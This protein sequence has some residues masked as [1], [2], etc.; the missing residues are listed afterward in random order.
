MKILVI[1]N[2]YL[3]KGGEDRV[4]DSE[5][6]M[7]KDAGNQV[8]YYKCSNNDIKSFGFFKKIKFLF[9]DINWNRKSYEEIKRIARE[10]K[11]DLAHIHNIFIYLSSSAYFA[12]KEVGI[13]VVQTLH[14][15]RLICLKGTFYAN[16]RICEDCLSGNYLKA[17]FK[18]CWRDSFILSAFLAKMLYKNT[19]SKI[20]QENV[21]AFI[22]LSEFSRNKFKQAGFPEDKLFIK[23]N[24]VDFKLSAEGKKRYGLFLGRL[25]DYKGVDTLLKA[26]AKLDKHYLKI[27]G[28]GPMLNEVKNR[29]K[30]SKNIQLL[31]ALP[32]E[33][34]MDYLRKAAFVIFP[35]ECY[36]NMPLTIIESLASATPV[37]ASDLGAMRGL[38]EDNITGLLF[39]AH[40][41][42][43]LVKK[44]RFLTDNNELY[45]KMKIN[46]RKCYEGRFTK[47]LNYEILMKIYNKAMVSQ[48]NEKTKN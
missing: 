36:E 47:Q 4:V 29:I 18:K 11:P 7:L 1:H 20:F 5:I 44:I 48:K 33:E 8:V 24:F 37:I 42:E 31:G 6:K 30:N 45:E 10:E 14:N 46:A 38:V 13:P 23:P 15:Y 2:Q 25:V 22:T 27:I 39:K 40:D 21:D 3:E 9:K 28:G 34:A 32:Y 17:V 19:K 35:S 12:L 26:Y 16:N 43:D 41:P